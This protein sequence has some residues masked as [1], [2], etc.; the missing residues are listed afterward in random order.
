MDEV[1][2][3]CSHATGTEL[4]MAKFVCPTKDSGED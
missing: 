4:R 2:Y 3:D 1:E